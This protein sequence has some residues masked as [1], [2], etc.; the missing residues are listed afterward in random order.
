MKPTSYFVVCFFVSQD[1]GNEMYLKS[2]EVATEVPL[3]TFCVIITLIMES[4]VVKEKTK[5][6]I[7]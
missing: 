7:V 1:P 2:M 6:R 4:V 5:G 3:S